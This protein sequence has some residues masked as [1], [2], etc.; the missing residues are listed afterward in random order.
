MRQRGLDIERDH[1]YPDL[2]F[3]LPAPDEGSA[4]SGPALDPG[5]TNLVGLGVMAYY[6]SN[7]ERRHAE[8]IYSTYVAQMK[9]L[10]L[11]LID[12]GRDVRLFVGDANG[13]DDA[14][15]QELLACVRSSRPD[16]A[17]SRI[18]SDP[19]RTFDDLMLAMLSVDIVIAM[20]YH[21]L[22]CAMKLSK[23]TLS[24]GYSPKHDVLM[25]DRGLERYCQSVESLDITRLKDQFRELESRSAEL[26]QFMRQRNTEDARLLEDQFAELSAVLFDAPRERR[27][28]RSMRTSLLSGG[29][30]S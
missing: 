24:I 3:A 17:P 27:T 28:S 22:V 21:N 23:P 16:L 29:S 7:D 9:E 11:W 20:R 13:S 25:A 8:S 14:V 6:G 1:V 4:T 30:T 12:S 10:L 19:V 2:V 5:N 18:I 26:C 15:V